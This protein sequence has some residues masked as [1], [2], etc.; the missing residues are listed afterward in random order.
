MG[1]IKQLDTL[2]CVAHGHGLNGRQLELLTFGFIRSNAEERYKRIMTGDSILIPTD[3]KKLCVQMGAEFDH[4]WFSIF[5]EIKSEIK[6]QCDTTKKQR[7]D[8]LSDFK[9]KWIQRN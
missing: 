6:L 2:N 8:T 4:A 3:I 7:I 1:K 5:D 9:R